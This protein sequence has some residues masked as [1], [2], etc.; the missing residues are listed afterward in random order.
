MIEITLE[1]LTIASFGLIFVRMNSKREIR[2]TSQRYSFSP[3]GVHWNE[4]QQ[5]YALDTGPEPLHE[6]RRSAESDVKEDLTKD[7]GSA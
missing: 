5:P 1:T 4:T 2:K 3:G 6:R 7:V